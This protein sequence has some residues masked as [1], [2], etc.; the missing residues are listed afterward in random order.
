MKTLNARVLVRR[1]TSLNWMINRNVIPLKGEVIVYTDAGHKDDGNGNIIDVPAIKIGDG[2]AYVVDLPFVGEDVRNQILQ[3][4]QT[5]TSNTTIHITQV[6]REKWDNK[7][8]CSL[9]GETLIFNK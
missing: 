6:E 1:D 2:L 5:H 8:D 3:E 4:L 7:I 9:S